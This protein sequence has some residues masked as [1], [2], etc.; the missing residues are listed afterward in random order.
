MKASIRKIKSKLDR[1]VLRTK[2][3]KARTIPS[4]IGAWMDRSK[5]FIGTLPTSKELRE[6]FADWHSF[7]P[8]HPSEIALNGAIA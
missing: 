6:E 7:E 1:S 5:D 4:S 2:K 8:I 3:S